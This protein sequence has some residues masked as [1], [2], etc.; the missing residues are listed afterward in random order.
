MFAH[1]HSHSIGKLAG[2]YIAAPE[3]CMR[4][5][6]ERA[7][8]MHRVVVGLRSSLGLKQQLKRAIL[9]RTSAILHIPERVVVQQ[10]WYSDYTSYIDELGTDLERRTYLRNSRKTCASTS[11]SSNSL[12]PV[13]IAT[14]N[15]V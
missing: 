10:A 6:G 2:I 14:D 8:T 4:M 5:V 11:V 7:S 15:S 12:L 13:R 9:N 3:M 1:P